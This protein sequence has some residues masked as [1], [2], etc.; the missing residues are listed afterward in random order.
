[1]HS[2]AHRRDI[3]E[4]VRSATVAFGIRKGDDVLDVLGAGVI[5]DPCG[6]IVTAR[7]V[8]DDVTKAVRKLRQSDP[9]VFRQ[10][11][12]FGET[13]FDH[14]MLTMKAHA[15][16]FDKVGISQKMDLAVLRVKDAPIPLTALPI[17]FNSDPREGDDIATCGFPYG[18]ELHLGKS[19]T[20]IFLTGIISSVD[21][22]P[23]IPPH[24]RHHYLLQLPTQ[25]G[26]SGGAVFD[27]NTGAVIGIISSRVEDKKHVYE[28]DSGKDLGEIDIPTGM[29]I[30]MPIHPLQEAIQS[31]KN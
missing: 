29:T 4:T 22:H 6:V 30:A 8:F 5:V 24:K 31:L 16:A 28:K 12:I 1:M 7:H 27:P 26:N 3:F 21:P 17:D 18:F 13:K 19:V 11:V 25:P 2:A 15:V 10:L 9:D 14:P 20:S 23:I